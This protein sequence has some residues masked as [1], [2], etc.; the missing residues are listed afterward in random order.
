MPPP[1][2]VWKLVSVHACPMQGTARGGGWVQVGSALAVMGLWGRL[3][4]SRCHEA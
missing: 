1:Y 3:A 2:V 4:I